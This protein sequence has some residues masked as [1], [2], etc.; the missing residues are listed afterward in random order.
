MKKDTASN[1]AADPRFEESDDYALVGDA[2]VLTRNGK[3]TAT[4]GGKGKGR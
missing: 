2:S 3:A 1:S 4:E